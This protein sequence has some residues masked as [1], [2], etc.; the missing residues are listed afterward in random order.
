[1]TA[2]S[3]LPPSAPAPQSQRAPDQY[4]GWRPADDDMSPLATDWR[5]RTALRRGDRA[6]EG[7]AQLKTSVDTLSTTMLSWSA[8]S[9]RHWQTASRLAW[10]VGPPLLVAVLLGAGALAWSWISTLHH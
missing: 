3:D 6:L 2:R 8:R 5:A 7:V 10:I 1:M 9:E 4:A